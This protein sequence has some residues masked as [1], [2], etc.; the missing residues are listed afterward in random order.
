MCEFNNKGGIFHPLTNLDEFEE[1]SG[2]LG[3]PMV[4][5]TINR[6]GDVIGGGL[7]SNDWTAFCGADTTAAE[8]DMIEKILQIEG[9]GGSEYLIGSC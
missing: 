7:V 6:G 9:T 1:L 3:I 8:I 2:L 5:G 4:A